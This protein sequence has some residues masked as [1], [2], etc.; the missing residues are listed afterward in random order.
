MFEFRKAFKVVSVFNG[1][2]RLRVVMVMRSRGT[3]EGARLTFIIAVNH[4]G[5]DESVQG[6]SV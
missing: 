1:V 2:N 5:V 6:V 4:P 3:S